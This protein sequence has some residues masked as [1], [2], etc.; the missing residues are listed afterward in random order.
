MT[1]SGYT[2]YDDDDRSQWNLIKWRGQVASAI[3]GKRGQTF[4]RELAGALDAMPQKRLIRD[5]FWNGEAC[6]LGVIAVNRGVYVMTVDPENYDRLADL[7]GIAHQLVQEIEYLN[8]EAYW[9][10]TPEERWSRMRAWVASNLKENWS[11]M[12][13]E[14]ERRE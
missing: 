4:L 12:T 10:A 9:H 14:P 2:D 7:L 1:R 13:T 5:E 6:A 11:N 3:R 8:D